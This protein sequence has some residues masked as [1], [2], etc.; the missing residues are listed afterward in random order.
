MHRRFGYFIGSGHRRLAK[1]NQ[2]NEKTCPA[3]Q[4][5]T[6]P[7]RGSTGALEVILIYLRQVL[8]DL[9]HI[10]NQGHTD[11]GLTNIEILRREN[12]L[13][14]KALSE[15]DRLMNEKL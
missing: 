10:H 9:H 5:E 14:R 12:E 13:L 3:T 1:E 11:N 8:A 4:S 7:V 2:T 6:E 15:L